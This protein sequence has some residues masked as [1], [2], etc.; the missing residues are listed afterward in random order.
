M[1]IVIEP[2]RL[3]GCVHIPPSKSM[4]HRAI[5][6][7]SLA[8]GKS[9]ITHIEYSKD[10]QA[11]IS[12]MKALGTMIFEYDDYLEIDGTTTFM[13][14]KCDID[15]CESGS[16]LRF[17]I[18]I[19]IVCESMIH[20]SGEGRLG[21]RPLDI[22]YKIFDEQHIAYLYKEDCLDLYIQGQLQPGVFHIPGNISSQFISGLLFALP[23][24]DGNSKIIITTP[25]ESKGYVD[26]TI[27][28]LNQFGISVINHD[29]QELIIKG[30]QCYRPC[31]YEVE[32]DFSQAA[33]YLVAGAL[34]NHV[35]MQGLNLSSYQGDKEAI[36]ILEMMGCQLICND[37]GYQ[38][39]SQQLHGT[40]ID[41]S[42]C[43]DIIPV[44]S[45]ACA[46]AKGTSTIYN[47]GRLRMKECDRLTA[48]VETINRLG[49]EAI[50]KEDAIV[51]NGVECLQGGNVCSYND[52]RM[53]MMEAIAST[54]CKDSVV[55]DNERC[56]EK[57]YPNFWKDF[58]SLGGRIK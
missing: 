58:Q 55:I 35:V 28:M 11:T 30:Q 1:S 57:S 45:L 15:C 37:N 22:Y 52:H 19:S 26:L 29:Y 48:T 41:G 47:V 21:Q 18:P 25:L 24:L 56:V 3:E 12:A 49:G 34:N 27:Q 2:N 14:N 13:K 51:I 23:L 10:I 4:A 8:R 44:I 31:Q 6:C 17:M 33:F 7:A 39:V 5:I 16:T 20:F 46:L 53:A 40:N 50:E 36:D 9:T 54:I 32:S 38:I 42:Q 43:P